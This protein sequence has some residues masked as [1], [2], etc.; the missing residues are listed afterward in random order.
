MLMI[1]R[2]YDK[3][4]IH[5]RQLQRPLELLRIADRVELHTSKLGSNMVRDKEEARMPPARV[6]S[7]PSHDVN[8]AESVW[9]RPELYVADFWSGGSVW[10][11][12]I[13][14]HG[15]FAQPLLNNF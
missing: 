2:N 7:P 1:P 10:R 12:H 5:T 4:W 6:E 11:R 13:F 14:R 15:R 9:R 8:S 3:L